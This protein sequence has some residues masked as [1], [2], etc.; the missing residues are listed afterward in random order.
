MTN[1]KL[2]GR[3]FYGIGIA[4]IGGMHFFYKGI[5]P[6]IAPFPPE[7][8]ANISILVYIMALYIVVS[9]LLIAVG[10]Y[11]KPTALILAMFFLICLVLGHVPGRLQNHPENIGFWTDAIKMLAL[12]GG[13]FIAALAYPE[14]GQSVV[15]DKL[16]E[17]APLGIWFYAFMLC[18]FGIEHL[19]A[20]VPISKSVPKY[21][22]W[23]VFWTYMAGV[24]LVGTGLS[25]L[26]K[27]KVRQIGL[28]MASVLFLWLV[29][30][31]LYYAVRFPLFRDGDNII[32]SFECLAF[33]GTV[34][35]ISFTYPRAT[36]VV[37]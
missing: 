11:V 22:P 16:G 15:F 17:M 31:H 1:L 14:E 2:Y 23:P 34:L 5:R 3:I 19:L 26:I 35:L 21:I 13:A 27:F 37:E 8:T 29:M 7:A 6:I 30:F 36:K 9:G 25:F 33:C 10:R 20:A 24:A 12:S 32:G 4:G 28:L 18:I